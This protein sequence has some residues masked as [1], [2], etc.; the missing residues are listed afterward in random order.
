MLTHLAGDYIENERT[1]RFATPLEDLLSSFGEEILDP[2]EE[3]FLL[4][5]QGVSSLDLDLVDAKNTSL[6]IPI[7][8]RDLTIRQS[9]TL[10]SSNREGGTTGAVVCKVSPLLAKHHG[11]THICTGSACA[12]SKI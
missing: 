8:G 12:G 1:S 2:E 3:S 11:K 4:F 10:L 6:E 7:S 9:P 5:T